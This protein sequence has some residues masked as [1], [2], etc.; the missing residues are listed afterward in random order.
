MAENDTAPQPD[1][2]ETVEPDAAELE[3]AAPPQEKQPD[4]VVAE[5]TRGRRTDK[6]LL[7]HAVMQRFGTPSYEAWDMTIPELI[8]K[9][10]A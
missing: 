5:A 2:P 4:P 3:A 8:E 7:V 10:E 6:S 1:E 9:L